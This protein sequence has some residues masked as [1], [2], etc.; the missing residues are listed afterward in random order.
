MTR[1][2]TLYLA[3]A[4]PLLILDGIW[5]TSAKSF[6]Q[7]QIGTIMLDQIRIAPAVIFYLIYVAGI[8]VFVL[9][10]NLV[11][12]TVWSTALSGA[13]LG[14]IAYGTYNATNYATL[15]DFTATV[16]LVD[17]TWGMIVTALTSVTAWQIVTWYERQ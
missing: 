16:M 15:K 8:V 1:F 4:I 6:Y 13:F 9:Q 17:W 3:A 10:P 7:G 11:N 2:M 12:G 5:L 14:L